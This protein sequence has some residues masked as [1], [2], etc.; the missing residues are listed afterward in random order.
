MAEEGQETARPYILSTHP[1]HPISLLTPLLNNVDGS[2]G[3]MVRAQL[4]LLARER[5]NV[6]RRIG[7]REDR[8]RGKVQR[9]RGGPFHLEWCARRKGAVGR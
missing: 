5:M 4:V 3:E 1:L 7:R 2:M 9:H 6:Q 8:Q